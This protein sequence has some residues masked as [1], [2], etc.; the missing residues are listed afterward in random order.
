MKKINEYWNIFTSLE[1]ISLITAFL[2]MIFCTI[3]FKDSKI[4]L[5][6]AFFGIM[7]TVLAGKG[8]I[9]CFY[10][11]VCG[12][13][14]YAYLAFSNA[15]WGNML[16]YLLYYIPMQILGIF[17]WKKN[18]DKNSDL[19][20][21]TKLNNKERLL[22]AFITLCITSVSVYILY[23]LGDKNPLLDG[24]TTIFSITGMILTIG[25]KFEQWIVWIIVNSISAIMW[26]MLLFNGQKV[27]S[28]AIMWT[29]YLIFAIIFFIQWKKELKEPIINCILEN[30]NL[31]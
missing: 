15:L 4:A 23:L 26:Y 30:D 29:V 24:I 13:S 20:I 7:Y 18:L 27:Y 6:G 10:F 1:R 19:I 8:K 3:F 31:K 22:Y 17:K 25:R 14:L 5:L 16:L 28:T 12:S 9:D 2:A 21:K 11:G